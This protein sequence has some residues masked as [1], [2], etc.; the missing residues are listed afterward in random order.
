MSH[1]LN[2]RRLLGALLATAA[3]PRVARAAAYPNGPVTIVVPFAAGGQFDS[4]ARQVGK[5]MA[6]DLGQP[7]IIENVGGA[8]GN[9]AA[10]RVARAKPDGQTVLMYGGNYAVAKSL[11]KKLDYDPLEDFV[12]ISRISLA[13]HVIMASTKS[14]IT[15]LAQLQQ[16][17]RQGGLSY[18]SPGV[19]TSMHLTFEIV[20]D[21]FGLDIVHI[22]YK[23]GAPVMTD[24]IGGQIDLGIIAVGPALEFI[25]T[26]KVVAL[27]VTS[28]AR[29]P[30]LPKVPAL[31]E[32]GVP[33][34]DAGSWAGFAVPKGT[35]APIVS[36]LNESVAKALRTP[37]LHKLFDE[38]SFIATPGTP[39]EMRAYAA[40][41]AQRYEPI[42]RK[43][44][45][46]GS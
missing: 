44:N 28:K 24:L 30:A 31:A 32:L 29:S 20:K 33:D 6:A 8:G 17:A 1:A 9:I 39:A 26:G 22:P 43:L 38:Q 34:L 23:G 27:A 21:Q 14:G 45:L 5:P 11:Y 37:E 12:P 40:R 25:R 19:G 10:S 46:Q 16:R 18:G 35:P 15:S 13:P 2:R 36:R 7:V 42:I 3:L 41:D 4:I